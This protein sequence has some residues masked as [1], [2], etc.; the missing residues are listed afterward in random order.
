MLR[1][2]WYKPLAFL[3]YV[4]LSTELLVA[5]SSVNHDYKDALCFQFKNVKSFN[6]LYLKWG[7]ACQNI[8]VVIGQGQEPWI[9]CLPVWLL[10]FSSLKSS[11]S[12]EQ[13]KSNKSCVDKSL[14]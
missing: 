13:G 1:T 9:R 6:L 2:H 10:F 4:Q 11:L 3:W 8:K 5:Q 14:F 7:A 12:K